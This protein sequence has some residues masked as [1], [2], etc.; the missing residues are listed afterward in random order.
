MLPK[1][2]EEKPEK[3]RGRVKG[4]WLESLVRERAMRN[5]LAITTVVCIECMREAGGS[6]LVDAKSLSQL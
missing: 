1:Q 5:K 2:V 3:E 4:G 6:V